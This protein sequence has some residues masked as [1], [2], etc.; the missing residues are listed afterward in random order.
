MI[1]YCIKEQTKAFLLDLID[2]SE[3]V[4]PRDLEAK[5]QSH[6]EDG[7]CKL[8]DAVFEANLKEVAMEIAN[9][10]ICGGE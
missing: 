4:G 10:P 9:I 8:D 5:C 7:E 1:P 6:V 2:L 3:L